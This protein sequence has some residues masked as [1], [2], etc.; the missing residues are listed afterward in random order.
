[1]RKI[2]I[3]VLSMISIGLFAQEPTADE[4]K[5]TVDGLKESY[6]ETKTTVDLLSKVKIS[7]YIQAQYQHADSNGIKSFEGGNFPTQ[8]MNR[9][10]IRRG[11]LKVAYSGTNS[12]Y[13]VQLD[14]TEK[15][16]SFKDIY[17][18]FTDPFIKTVSLQ[19]GIFN[20]P[21]GYEIEYSSSAR[22]TPE[23]SRMFQTLF[24]GERDLG[25]AVILSSEKGLFKYLNF[26]GGW[27]AGNGI[28]LETDNTK[29][30]IGKLSFKLPVDEANGFMID[31]GVSTYYGKVTRDF[32]TKVTATG[33]ATLAD[34]TKVV[35]PPSSTPT[36][37]YTYES[38][39]TNNAFAKTDSS[40][41]P[42]VKRQYFGGDIQM[43][44]PYLSAVSFMGPTKIMAEYITG[45]QPGTKTNNAFYQVGS[46]DLYLRNFAGYYVT[47]VQNFTKRFQ[48]MVKYDVWDPN[49]KVKG[50][51]VKTEGDVAYT[52]LGYGLIY[53]YDSNI[54]FT[55]YYAG[56]KNEITSGVKGYGTDLKDN[57]LTARIQYKF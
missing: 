56:V 28:A 48:V 52:T 33:T 12:Q 29:D 20:R 27:F 9:M 49:T 2:L 35:T 32:Q 14:V 26:K 22:E 57:V 21:F 3:T 4:L 47:F 17:M 6:N 46:G 19:S 8:S 24:P 54:K 42:L 31:G 15:G 38:K 13:V 41:F 11:R 45:M 10:M 34:G 55:L 51:N 43:Y 25:A 23:R 40:W 53:N 37:N 5:Q 44:I 16:V 1:M 30:F 7:G 18:V 36:Q 39:G 50:N